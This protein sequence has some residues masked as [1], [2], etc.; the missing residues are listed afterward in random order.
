M[1]ELPN[2]VIMSDIS[3]FDGMNI[4]SCELTS[5]RLREDIE[6]CKR[7]YINRIATE[8]QIY[9]VS[10]SMNQLQISYDNDARMTDACGNI[11]NTNEY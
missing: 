6:R 8:F 5:S 4:H 10:L 11:Y 3:E 9:E 7:E 1:F 2:D